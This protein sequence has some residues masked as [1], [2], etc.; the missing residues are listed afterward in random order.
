MI[1]A[2]QSLSALHAADVVVAMS[3]GAG[4]C[5]MSALGVGVGVG[6]GAGVL[7][8]GDELPDEPP[9]DEPLDDELPPPVVCGCCVGWYA[10]TVQ[11][12]SA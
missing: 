11:P 10:V 3:G 9:D 7:G 5:A 6:V 12:T 1:W 4:A 2:Q 8:A